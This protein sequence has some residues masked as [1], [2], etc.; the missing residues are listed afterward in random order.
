MRIS[1]SLAG[2]NGALAMVA[3][4]FAAHSAEKVVPPEQ[5]ELIRR[6]A[7]IHL[8][9]ALA[10][11]GLAALASKLAGNRWLTVGTVAFQTGIIL[12]SGSLYWLGLM[13]PDTL[14]PFALATPLGGLALIAGWAS[15]A[16]A[17]LT[18]AARQ[19]KP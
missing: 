16:G 2:L 6:G 10:L 3:L 4:S 15:L 1:L 19:W 18:G 9:H 11:L 8:W 13:G 17:G 12:F 14:D 7:E 5:I